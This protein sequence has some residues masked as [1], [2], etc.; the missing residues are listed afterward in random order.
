MCRADPKLMVTTDDLIKACGEIAGALNESSG[1]KVPARKLLRRLVGL[2]DWTVQCC[3]EATRFEH[4][5]AT[6]H[7]CSMVASSRDMPGSL[8]E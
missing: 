7:T 1:V 6:A 3:G 4:V 8:R 2:V 5:V